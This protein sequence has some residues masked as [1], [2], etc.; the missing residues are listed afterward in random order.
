ML[1]TERCELVKL[2]PKDFYDIKK[3]Y[4]NEA[5]RKYLGGTWKEEDIRLCIFST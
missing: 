2:K 3:I 5:V 4:L 1:K